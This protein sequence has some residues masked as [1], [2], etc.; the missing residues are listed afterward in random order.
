MG[1]CAKLGAHELYTHFGAGK[2]LKLAFDAARIVSNTYRM[3]GRRNA[4]KFKLDANKIGILSDVAE[5][6]RDAALKALFVQCRLGALCVNFCRELGIERVEDLSYITLED[7][8][9]VPKYLKDQFKGEIRNKLLALLGL[10]SPSAAGRHKE[11]V[12]TVT[13]ASSA[14]DKRTNTSVQYQLC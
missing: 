8:D 7:V 1:A 9:D 11:V 5:V 6:A 13:L 12:H 2:S 4:A 14:L 3:N 10:Q